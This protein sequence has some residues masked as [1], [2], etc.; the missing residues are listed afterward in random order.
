MKWFKINDKDF[1]ANLISVQYTIEGATNNTIYGRKSIYV[2]QITKSCDITIEVQIT[3]N[4]DYNYI[5]KIY[6]NQYVN[7]SS[8]SKFELISAEFKAYGCLIK[9]LT[10]DTNNILKIEI[11]SDHIQSKD[12]SDRR[13]EIIE[14]ILDKTSK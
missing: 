14:Q 12:L 6:D 2:P 10:I 3:N 5:T 11:V 8:N 4:S 1:T 7:Y 13:D 9:A